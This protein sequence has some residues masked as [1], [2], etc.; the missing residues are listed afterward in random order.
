MIGCT[1]RHIRPL[2]AFV[3]NLELDELHIYFWRTIHTWRT[4]IDPSATAD[5]CV[6]ESSWQASMIFYVGKGLWKLVPYNAPIFAHLKVYFIKSKQICRLQ[7]VDLSP[8]WYACRFMA[9]SHR[10][11][12]STLWEH[13]PHLQLD[14]KLWWSDLARPA[15]VIVQSVQCPA[16][17]ASA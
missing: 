12:R 2:V 4:M 16:S 11:Q 6:L 1:R 8:Y 10:I 5:P 14:G 3:W 13:G 9:G 7:A 17:K 15:K